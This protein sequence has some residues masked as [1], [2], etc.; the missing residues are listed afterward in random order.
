MNKSQ[1]PRT[2]AAMCVLHPGVQPSTWYVQ[3]EKCREIE[4]DLTAARAEVER[5]REALQQSEPSAVWYDGA[6]PFPYGKEWFIAEITGDKSRVVIKALPEEF[7]YAYRT[8]DHTYYMAH[9]I[10]RWMQFPDS[11]YKRFDARAALAAKEM[12]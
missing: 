2:D 4:R 1:T 5:L 11:E 7:T 3:A 12:K 9:R 8:A 6:P 10:S